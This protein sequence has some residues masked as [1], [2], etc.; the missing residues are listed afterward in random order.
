M[1]GLSQIVQG[2]IPVNIPVYPYIRDHEFDGRPVYPAVESMRLISGTLLAQDI[3]F[4]PLIIQKTD[5][6]KFI[7]ISDSDTIDAHIDVVIDNGIIA[8]L[9]SVE[10]TRS[11]ITRHREYVRIR[12]AETSAGETSSR[13]GSDERLDVILGLTGIGAEI[14]SGPIYEELVPFKTAYRNISGNITLTDKGAIGRVSGGMEV[15]YSVLGS[16]FPLDAAFHMACVWCQRYRG[17]V[18]FPVGFGSRE[19]YYPAVYNELYTARIT[20][21]SEEGASFFFDLWIIDEKGRIRESVRDLR[22]QD[23]SGGTRK[24]P[25]WINKDIPF[26]RQS[27]IETDN[28]IKLELLELSGVSDTAQHVLSGMEIERFRDLG[29]KRA[30]SF[31]AS[32]L[33]L[34]KLSRE[35]TGGRFLSPCKINTMNEDRAPVCPGAAGMPVFCSVSHDK[36]FA[37]AVSSARRVGIDI[38]EMGGRILKTNR[39]Y[40][41]DTE[42]ELVVSSGLEETTASLRIWTV[43]EAV[44]KASGYD[45]VRTWRQC[46]VKKIGL[47]RSEVMLDGQGFIAKH[48]E[49]ENHLMTI[50]IIDF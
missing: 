1:E 21:V 39:L 10:K 28:G 18:G 23:V 12:F 49:F 30:R 36:R 24:P 45:L 17:V 11:G 47:D 40:M 22:M 14:G 25:E 29:S 8:T 6:L 46:E 4:N 7:N 15:D 16:P 9:G 31:L 26:F 32:R 50:V 19:I 44:S 41:S 20:P 37:V 3:K 48:Y 5:F 33:L 34:K 43:K 35:L 42:L 13:E 27:G 38:E 2:R